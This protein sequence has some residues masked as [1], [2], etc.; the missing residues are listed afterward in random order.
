VP[1][2][3]FE[4]FE[5]IAVELSGTESKVITDE[6][7]R[8]NKDVSPLSE[9]L[10]KKLKAASVEATI[11][12]AVNELQKHFEAKGANLPFSY[13]SQTGRFTATDSEFLSFVTE[14]KDMRSISNRSRDFECG[15]AGRLRSRATGTIHRVGH[16]RD[17]KKL[18]RQFNRYL[19]KLG[20]DQPVCLGR[21]KDGGFDVLWLLPIGT[22]PHR[23]IVS[24][25][26]KN[27]EFEMDG[28]DKSV[29]AAKR[30][31]G[32]N[33][34]LQPSV[35]VPCVI[36]NDYLHPQ[37]LTQKPLEFVPLG[38]SDLASLKQS[39]SVDLI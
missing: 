19:R 20:F 4:F 14:M 35:H 1:E 12:C 15:V 13:D 28:A 18:Q 16:P 6:D 31:F 10:M 32:Q 29:A 33:H 11:P 34:H 8:I 21:E 3:L 36:F 26:C 24:V 25:Q 22:I 37:R 39:V 2:P 30:S 38:L 5:I 17:K 27:G 7:F 23:P 9:V